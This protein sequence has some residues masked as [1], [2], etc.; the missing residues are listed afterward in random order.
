[1]VCCSV[2]HSWPFSVYKCNWHVYNTNLSFASVCLKTFHLLP[3]TFKTHPHSLVRINGFLFFF[4][5][6]NFCSCCFPFTLLIPTPLIVPGTGETQDKNLLI[7]MKMRNL[8]H[9]ISC[10]GT[11]GYFKSKKNRAVF[12]YWKSIPCKTLVSFFFNLEKRHFYF[13]LLYFRFGICKSNSL[14]VHCMYVGYIHKDL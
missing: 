11:W 13:G 14:P 9:I 1:M 12:K 8:K 4:F 2:G 3:I 6:L 10:L 7:T 5:C